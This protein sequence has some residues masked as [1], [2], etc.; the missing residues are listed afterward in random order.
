MIVIC[1]YEH[2]LQLIRGGEIADGNIIF[3]ERADEILFHGIAVTA[4]S[5]TAALGYAPVDGSGG[6][7]GQF[8]VSD[9]SGG[10][11]WTS[12]VNVGEVGM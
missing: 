3:P 10:I 8:A 11:V 2:L 7:A 9:G 6:L 1:G 12:L 4:E 5:I